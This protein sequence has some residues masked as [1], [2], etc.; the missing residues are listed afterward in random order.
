MGNVIVL[1]ACRCIAQFVHLNCAMETKLCDDYS[2]YGK[3]LSRI[4]N[5]NDIM[6]TAHESLHNKAITAYHQY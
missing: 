3:K 2:V 5:S 6:D 1:Q 4:G